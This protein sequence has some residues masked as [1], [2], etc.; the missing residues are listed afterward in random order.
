MELS[1]KKTPTCT[2]LWNRG[3]VTLQQK[4]KEIPSNSPSM[5][6]IFKNEVSNYKH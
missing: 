4:N 1:K 2:A 5:G 6:R 3:R